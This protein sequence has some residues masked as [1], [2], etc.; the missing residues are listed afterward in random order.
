[1][2]AHAKDA[3]GRPRIAQIFYFSLAVSTSEAGRAKGLISR[4]D[5]QVFDLVAAC[6]AAVCAIVADEGA[7]AEEEE[8]RIG[9]EEGA[10]S[11]ATKAIQMPSVAGWKR[12]EM[13]VSALSNT[14]REDSKASQAGGSQ[15][16]AFLFPFALPI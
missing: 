16:S 6:A 7:I 4:Q 2:T 11:I 1:M 13:T 15:M 5:G 8:V 9:V 10:A 14:E 3:L 12:K